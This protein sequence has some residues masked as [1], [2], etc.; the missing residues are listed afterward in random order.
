MNSKLTIKKTVYDAV[1]NDIVEGRYGSDDI[2]TEGMLVEKYGVSKS[3]IREAL[4]EL[5]KDNVLRSLPRMGYQIVPVS[6]QEIVD[7]L[8]FRVDLELSNL[9]RVM[10]NKSDQAI[11]NLRNVTFYA[12]SDHDREVMPN[13]LLNQRFHLEL[14]KIGGNSYTYHVLKETLHRSARFASHYFKTAWSRA[15]ESQGKYHNAILEALDRNDFHEAEDMLRSD[16]L[17]VKH[18]IQDILKK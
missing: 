10:D 15:S 9:R 17:A 6:L 7:L 5:C 4:I 1:Y 14:C 16:I 3:P 8:D 11:D 2:L 13:W 18:E 12:D